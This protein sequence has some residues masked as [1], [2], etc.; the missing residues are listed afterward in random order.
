ML[1]LLND[2]ERYI[3]NEVAKE[4]KCKTKEQENSEE[5]LIN[6]YQNFESNRLLFSAIMNCQEKKLS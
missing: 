5:I 4:V 6:A 2:N 1:Q 3:L